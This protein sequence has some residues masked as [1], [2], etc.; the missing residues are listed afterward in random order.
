MNFVAARPSAVAAPDRDQEVHRDQDDLEED[1]EQHEVERHERAE[2]ADFE[3]QRQRE[4]QPDAARLRCEA[5]R[6]GA[7]TA[8]SA[9]SVSSTSGRQM[10][11]TPRWKRTSTPGSQRT[12]TTSAN[13]LEWSYGETRSDCDRHGERREG[14]Q[15]R[16]A[17]SR[18]AAPAAAKASTTAPRAGS[19]RSSGNH[20]LAVSL[21]W[22]PPARLRRRQQGR[23]PRD[24]SR[25]PARC[26]S[27]HGATP[28]RA[29]RSLCPRRPPS[30]RRRRGR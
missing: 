30:R 5:H 29:D 28:H 14:D 25:R 4:Q 19:P 17:R 23:R 10:P 18:C 16:E 21:I 9:A 27:V 7:R 13:R 15:Q 12:S 26:R 24:R 2:H 20:A 11:S 8:P 3:Q 1:E 22:P 6:V